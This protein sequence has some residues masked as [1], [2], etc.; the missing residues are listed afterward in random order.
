M[1]MAL[2]VRIA[3]SY[4]NVNRAWGSAVGRV[5]PPFYLERAVKGAATTAIAGRLRDSRLS[6]L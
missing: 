1:P 4:L 5:T 3:E 6:A 2:Q